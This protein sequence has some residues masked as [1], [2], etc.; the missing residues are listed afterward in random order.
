MSGL[1][2]AQLREARAGRFRSPILEC[3][4]VPRISPAVVHGFHSSFGVGLPHGAFGSCDL[5]QILVTIKAYQ[6]RNVLELC[7]IVS[8]NGR[9]FG[10]IYIPCKTYVNPLLISRR[11]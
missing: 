6:V 2:G 3:N 4:P 11:P 9:G 1:A 8:L 7:L 10:M 5:C